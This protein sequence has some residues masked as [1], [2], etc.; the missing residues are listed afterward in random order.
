MPG[1]FNRG[2]SFRAQGSLSKIPIEYGAGGIVS[3]AGS[4]RSALLL[5]SRDVITKCKWC[6]VVWLNAGV[7]G[8]TVLE[9][10]AGLQGE[11]RY[12]RDRVKHLETVVE[13]MRSMLAAIVLATNA[14]VGA[15]QAA[16]APPAPPVNSTEAE[17]KK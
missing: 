11:V 8:A 9:N 3:P 13:E 6:V 15:P 7:Q 12:L 14:E 1:S 2:G 17:T 5:A 10:P 16:P 4:F